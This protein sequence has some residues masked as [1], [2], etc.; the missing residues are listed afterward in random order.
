MSALST[1]RHLGFSL[2][3]FLIFVL[4]LGKHE[5]GVNLWFVGRGTVCQ[6]LFQDGFLAVPWGWSGDVMGESA[7]PLLGW[8]VM[9]TLPLQSPLW[10]CG[11]SA[12]SDSQYFSAEHTSELIPPTSL[13]LTPN[14]SCKCSSNEMLQQFPC[15]Q[16]DTDRVRSWK[17]LSVLCC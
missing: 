12:K 10:A 15:F 4:P 14:G 9:P 5:P 1:G 7:A 2:I 8:V 16:D 6:D 11:V 3:C 13:C 17:S